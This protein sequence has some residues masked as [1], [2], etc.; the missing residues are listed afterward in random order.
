MGVA[1]CDGATHGSGVIDVGGGGTVGEVLSILMA[2]SGAR[3]TDELVLV[4]GVLSYDS[5]LASSVVIPDHILVSSSAVDLAGE[6]SLILLLTY[7]ALVVLSSV[8]V[9]ADEGL[10]LVTVLSDPVSES[11]TVNV[12]LAVLISVEGS[13]LVVVGVASE[14][15]LALGGRATNGALHLATRG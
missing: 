6:L 4:S 1:H 2:A 8:T 5:L 15:A 13:T 7:N 14:G 12:T 9:V 10:S 3:V 11:L